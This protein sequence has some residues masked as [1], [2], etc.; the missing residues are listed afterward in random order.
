MIAAARGVPR[1]A[2]EQGV[3]QRT[4][5]AD[6]LD[7]VGEGA[8]GGVRTGSPGI[9]LVESIAE[10]VD[11]VPPGVRTVHR[12]V[13]EPAETRRARRDER[14]TSSGSSSEAAKKVFD[15]CRIRARHAS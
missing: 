3:R 10:P 2:V 4:G 12:V 7:Q 13:G 9:E 8:V 15:P 14:R 11:G 5:K 1:E 6:A